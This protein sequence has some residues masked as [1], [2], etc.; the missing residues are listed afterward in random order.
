MVVKAVVQNVY[1]KELIYF[2]NK[3]HREAWKQLTQ[4]KS[5]EGR[6]TIKKSEVESL[7][8]FGIEIEVFDPAQMI[9]E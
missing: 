9:E 7:R 1:G 4:T 6:S 2:V 3:K 5:K 8:Q